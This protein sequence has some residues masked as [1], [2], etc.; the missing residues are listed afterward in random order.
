MLRT[1]SEHDIRYAASLDGLWDFVVAPER[2]DR[3]K[4]PR[5][6]NRKLH[7]PAA[8]ETT[9][10]LESYR[11]RAWLRRTFRAV[12]GTAV[13]L[14]F[15]GV[16][17][18]AEVYVDGKRCGEHYDAFTPFEVVLPELA[19]GEHELVVAVDNRFGEHSALHIE[20]DY[21]TYG[22]I[23]RPVELQ[24]LEPLHIAHLA[25]TPRRAGEVWQLEVAVTL[26]NVG[27]ESARREVTLLLGDVEA[28]CGKVTVKPGQSRTLRHT[29]E[30]LDVEPWDLGRANLYD[31]RACLW[32]GEQLVD[33]LRDR[34]GFRDIAVRGKRILLNGRSIRLRG[35]NRH[36]DHPQFGCAVPL[37]AM[38]A[39]LNLIRDLGCNFVRTSHYPNDLRFL[40]LCDELGLA[41]WEESHARA[42]DMSHPKFIEQIDA[43]TREMVQWHGN[44][45][46]VLM[47]GCLNECDS[48]T[49]AGR[50]HYARV[51]KLLRKL[52]ASRPLTFASNRFENDRCLGLVDIVA[53]NVYT[54]WYGGGL[55]DIKPRIDALLKWIHSSKSKGG[56]GKPVILSE[57]GAGGNYGN[58]QACRS[59]WSEEYQADA[60]AA[61][62][63]VY[64]NHKDIAATAI[65]QFCDVRITPGWQWQTRPRTMNNKG[66]VDEFRRPKLAYDVVKA[67][68]LQAA[69]LAT[70]GAEITK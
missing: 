25:A 34:V 19:E 42:V 41:V 70:T 20:N 9:P 3:A 68:H 47:W 27:R 29:L 43:S 65:W 18:T 52:D 45:P 35:V 67:K 6:Y 46:C 4:L 62:L 64:L 53:M 36:E 59:F 40:D 5:T 11:G 55:D 16:S 54:G 17:H 14:V 51:L 13:R 44:R 69:E 12:G 33:D 60:L 66:T 30:Q 8:W 1:F 57:F 7:V 56:K 38:V 61:Q 49:A 50:K 63:E 28:E 10:G 21:Y 58:R 31:L 48:D 37:A 39:D 26:R 22:G 24:W 23:T 15:G 2:T 32:D